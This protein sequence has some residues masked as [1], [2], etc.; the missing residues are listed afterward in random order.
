[1]CGIFGI[2]AGQHVPFQ[3]ENLR[4][5][6]VEF[7]L[8]AESRGK[9]AS[10]LATVLP[11]RIEVV[12]RPVRGRALLNDSQ[13]K[14][15]L[16]RALESTE[17]LTIMGHTRMVTNGSADN[18][19]NNQPV[20]KDGH[21]VFH[22]GIIVN[23]DALWRNHPN[24][25]RVAEVDTEAFLAIVAD[26]RTNGQSLSAATIQ[27]V[28]EARGANT[29]AILGEHDNALIIATTNGSMFY[30]VSRSS[31][32]AVFASERYILE[33]ICETPALIPHFSSA[34]VVQLQAGLAM[35]LPLDAPIPILFSLDLGR[36]GVAQTLPHDLLISSRTTVDH[37][38]T[39]V[40][41]PPKPTT[42]L[43][44]VERLMKTDT[45]A[46][47][48]LRRCTRCVLPETFPFMEFDG[49]GVCQF[50]R[51]YIRYK[52]QPE[53]EL[54]HYADR[55]RRNDGRPDCLVPFSGGR[56]SSF[57]LHFIKTELKL[58]PVA[59]T[60]DWGMVTDLARRNISRMCE[61]L[62]VEHIL[63]A[64]DIR[65]KREFIRL[66]VSAWLKKPH[67]GTIPLFMAGDKQFFYL[68]SMLRRQMGLDAIIF[69]M[70][71]LEKTDFKV[72]FCGINDPARREKTYGL[73]SINKMWLAAFYGKEFLRNPAYLNR[74][75]PDSIFAFFS[76]YLRGKDYISIFDYIPWS[77][78]T[79]TETLKEYDW[80]R[81][82]DTVSTWR[83]GDGTA[84]FYN[85]IYYRLAGFSEH[86]TFRSNQIRESLISRDQALALIAKEN[87]PQALSFKW[88]LDTIGLDPVAVLKMINSLPTLYQHAATG[89]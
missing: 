12:K 23:D 42:N 59:F 61:S 48:A 47:A 16:G 31:A 53:S 60:Y 56:D 70:N 69:S 66:N 86:D 64:A 83:I 87:Q 14:S 49:Q 41:Q 27:A 81:S 45:A 77:E 75:I 55:I 71:R 26:A 18:H 72:G 78:E 22:N 5:T 88:Y 35:F 74:S 39:P 13:F 34:P 82:P 21:F 50:C 38:D 73:S 2:V 84:P 6:M 44:K 62:K 54:R 63:L 33:K 46:I 67:L 20:L 51:N 7:Y 68:A 15:A 24:L 76:Y 80:E 17:S 25:N 8:L 85:Y 36:A 43:A 65:Q 11:D 57:G 79:I 40:W 4:Q 9:E 29:F 19:F 52:L 1:M 89:L 3:R 30:S 37:D 32:I 58:N 28:R 10:G